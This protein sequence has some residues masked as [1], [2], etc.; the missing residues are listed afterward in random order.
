MNQYENILND[1]I[2]E[3]NDFQTK[4]LKAIFNTNNNYKSHIGYLINL[5]LYL[6]LKNIIKEYY[7][8]QISA[9]KA[10]ESINKLN[11]IKIKTSTYLI[12][13]LFNGNKYIIINNNL[14]DLFGDNNDTKL[15]I[16]YIID[17]DYIIFS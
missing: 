16:S 15:S 7:N 10:Y 14:W 11:S 2:L 13:K 9:K 8:N 4:H 6:N 3:I 1:Y 17:R 12:N 5:E